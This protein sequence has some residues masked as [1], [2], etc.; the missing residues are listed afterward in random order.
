MP[1]KV[2]VSR[3]LSSESA[4]FQRTIIAGP[5]TRR[6]RR[7]RVNCYRFPHNHGLVSVARHTREIG[8]PIVIRQDARRA[9]T[10]EG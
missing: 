9:E 8:I 1:D 5:Y 10:H 3:P 7:H 2:M 4:P 6:R